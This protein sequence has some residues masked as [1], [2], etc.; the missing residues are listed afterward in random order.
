VPGFLAT[1]AAVWRLAIPY[2]RSSEDRVAGRILL[3]AIVALELGFVG[4]TVLVNQWRARFYNALQELNWDVFVRELWVF[5]LLAGALIV[6]RVYQL[7]LNQWL[8][9][10]WR[11]FLTAR[12]LGAWLAD[13]T[14]YRMQMLGDAADN[15]DQRIAEDV[16]QFI[17]GGSNGVGILP[18][19]LGLLNAVVTLGSFLLILWGLSDAAKLT[20]FG[21]QIPGFLFWAALIYAIAGTLLT[22]FIGRVLTA[23]NFNQQRYEADF[24]FSLVRARENAEQ[25]ALLHGESAE[26]DRLRDRFSTLATNWLRIMKRTKQLSFFTY[27]Y[28]QAS[29]IFPYLVVS[30]A[31]FAG[32]IQLGGLMQTAD[33]FSSVQDA[34]SFFVNV[35]RSFAEWR[36]V[37]ARLAGFETAIT[38]AGAIGTTTPAIALVRGDAAQIR[39]D[40]V[41][42]ELPNGKPQVSADGITF[43]AHDQVLVN[44]PS[45]SGKSMLFRAIAGIW[46]F[47]KGT[48]SLPA[49]ARTMTLPQRPYLPIGTLAGA[50]SYPAAEGAFE[51]TR[52]AELLR[53]V[54]LPALAERLTEDT[55]WSR[56]L[57]L[58]EQ[59]RVGVA[60]AI[61]Q[62]PDY[63]LLD[64][65]TAS[66]DEPAEAALYRLL[67]ERLPNTTI[68][69]IGHRST[70]AAFHTRRLVLEREGE[71]Y[72]VKETALRPT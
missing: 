29:I 19:G 57:S 55:H 58:G 5:G 59:Q 36:A 10:R 47:G 21:W 68:V 35:Y 39:L 49:N 8:Q 2:F 4:I 65:A 26:R 72:V 40:G 32:R 62:A 64:E 48:V 46:P 44:G 14:H 11:R 69:S 16:R 17:D 61:L 23:L 12:Y 43:A 7:Y 27:G 41:V 1:L 30:P 22:H 38:A 28:G 15:P 60:R 13:G 33:A 51:A 3:G 25:I 54:G 70:L 56:I 45:G 42:V 66:L 31:F 18:I 53:A 9:I 24:R 20:L 50:V 71:R 63:L 67:R 6:I 34:L 37:I 52:I